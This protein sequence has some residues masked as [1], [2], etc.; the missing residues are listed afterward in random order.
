MQNLENL[1]FIF[2]KTEKVVHTAKRYLPFVEIAE[3]TRLVHKWKLGF[4]SFRQAD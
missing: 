4:G 1:S 3:K 2:G